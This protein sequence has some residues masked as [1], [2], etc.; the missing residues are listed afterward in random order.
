[1]HSR[2][3]AVDALPG[4]R[5]TQHPQPEAVEAGQTLLVALRDNLPELPA[6]DQMPEAAEADQ[7]Q[8]AQEAARAE[9]QIQVLE[10]GDRILRAQEAEVQIQALEEAV[11]IQALEVGDRILQEL[12]VAAQ[13]QAL[14]EEVQ[15]QEPEA[16][17]QIQA[18]EVA[19][20][21]LVAV[22]ARQT[23]EVHR[24]A[25]RIQAVDQIHHLAVGQIQAAQAVR[26][27][28]EV[29]AVRQN[30]G[31]Q[32]VRHTLEAP[33]VRQ[34]PEVPVACQM[35][36]AAAGPQIPEVPQAHP[37]ERHKSHRTCRRASLVRHNEGSS[38]SPSR[39]GGPHRRPHRRQHIVLSTPRIKIEVVVRSSTA[40]VG[41]QRQPTRHPSMCANVRR[42]R[43]EVA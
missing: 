26:H 3:D 2:P 1:M 9:A 27:T 7:I 20:R 16:E 4:A 41:E 32:A 24:E 11:Q 21:R 8:A 40:K 42:P 15:I 22:G 23:L 36:E 31:V 19:L 38:W 30:P 28:L 34:T 35:P 12:E 25:V 17:V 14:V 18:P 10:V 13:S 6:A 43:S 37:E 29:L 5:D 33:A 39:D